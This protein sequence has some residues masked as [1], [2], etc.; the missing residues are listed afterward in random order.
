MGVHGRTRLRER[1]PLLSATHSSPSSALTRPNTLPQPMARPRALSFPQT[2][3]CLPSSCRCLRPGRQARAKATHSIWGP[4]C[5]GSCCSPQGL[6]H[7]QPTDPQRSLE[8]GTQRNIP[9]QTPQDSLTA[10]STACSSLEEMCR[11]WGNQQLY[12]TLI[13]PRPLKKLGS[14]CFTGCRTPYTHTHRAG[15][16]RR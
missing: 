2:H 1:M 15:T 13:N 12:G 16:G 8:P 9:S 3:S 5:K 14:L 11:F 10:H 7:R 6:G 4:A